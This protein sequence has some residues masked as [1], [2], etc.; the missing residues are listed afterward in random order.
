SIF[1]YRNYK[2]EGEEVI[3]EGKHLRMGSMSMPAPV[4]HMSPHQ[5]QPPCNP[6]FTVRSQSLHSVEGGEEEGSPTSR[7]QPPPKPRRDPSTKL[8]ISSEAVD[9]SPTGS[10]GSQGCIEDCRKVPPPKPK[11]NPNTQLSTSFDESYIRNHGSKGSPTMLFSSDVQAPFPAQPQGPQGSDLDEP[12]YIEM[13]GNVGR[14][15]MLRSEEDEPGEAVYEE[16]KYPGLDEF[17]WRWDISSCRS[18]CATPCIPELDIH[19]PLSRCTTPRGTPVCDIPAPFPNLLT[20]R[21][22]LLV[23]PPV[24]AQCSPNSDESPLTPL[25]VAKLPMLENSSYGKSP[26]SSSLEP[27]GSAST[28]HLRRAERELTA[29]PTITVSGRSSAPPLP[30]ALYKSSSSSHGYQRSHSACPSPVIFFFLQQSKKTTLVDQ[31]HHEFARPAI[32]SKNQPDLFWKSTEIHDNQDWSF[33]VFSTDVSCSSVG[34]FLAELKTLPKVGRSSSTTPAD[35]QQVSSLS[36]DSN[37]VEMIERKQRLCREIRSQERLADRSPCKK[38]S[39]P[40]MPSW[41]KTSGAKKHSPPPYPT[42]TTVFWDTAI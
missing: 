10:K 31:R 1:H 27:S 32:T 23:F 9:L 24:P 4:E 34:N 33:Q 18:Q 16:M 14:E 15:L 30:C 26:T 35:V 25:D 11:R 37:M 42:Q 5:Y 2:T 20:H 28:P 39:L 12:V 7:K 22:P 29:T 38:E 41:K 36:L 13:S 40:T 6:G 8:S 19:A 17:D 3:T 21:P